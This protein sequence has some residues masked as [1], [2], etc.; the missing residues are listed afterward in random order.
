MNMRNCKTVEEVVEVPII[1]EIIDSAYFSK[2]RQNVTKKKDKE[3][4][5]LTKH[6]KKG[7]KKN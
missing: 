7:D 6:N 3:K 4:N 5:I 2:I 1:R